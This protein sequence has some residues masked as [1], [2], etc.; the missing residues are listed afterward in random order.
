MKYPRHLI[1]LFILLLLTGLIRPLSLW[2][3]GDKTQDIRK[4]YETTIRQLRKDGF[5]GIDKALA[6]FNEILKKDPDFLSAHVS[7]ADALLLKYEFS[8]Q[9]NPDWLRQ[10]LGHL[11]FCIK[12]EKKKR[13]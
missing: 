9:K 5:K 12:K 7:A 11:D 8:K 10:A 3:A 4:T 2:A 1:L 6:S 13:L